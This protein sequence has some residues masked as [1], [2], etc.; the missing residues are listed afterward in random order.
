MSSV[1]VCKTPRQ[2][3]VTK[4]K[5]GFFGIITPHLRKTEFQVNVLLWISQDVT[6]LVLLGSS[7]IE[8]FINGFG[9][10]KKEDCPVQLAVGIDTDGTQDVST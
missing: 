8:K 9:P 1:H 3:T 2:K 10:A 5:A 7:F 6:L 4:Q